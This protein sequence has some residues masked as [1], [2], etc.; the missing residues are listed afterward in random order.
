V[1][2]DL[3]KKLKKFEN[4]MKLWN[5]ETALKTIKDFKDFPENAY[6]L[7][8]FLMN[9]HGDL[10]SQRTEYAYV[11]VPK[12]VNV[13]MEIASPWLDHKRKGGNTKPKAIAV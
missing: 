3:R 5:F 8:N 2:S 6:H 9:N 4:E 12:S 10:G 1:K 13:I 7:I 11:N